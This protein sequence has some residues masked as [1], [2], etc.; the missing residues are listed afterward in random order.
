MVIDVPDFLAELGMEKDAIEML[1]AVGYCAEISFYYLL[2]V[3]EYTVKKQR[4]K[5]N[6]KVQFKL[7]NKMFFHQYDKG[8]FCQLPINALD[9]DIFL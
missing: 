1:K 6:K 2:Q 5:T 8:N 4:N 9:E 7:E 3:G